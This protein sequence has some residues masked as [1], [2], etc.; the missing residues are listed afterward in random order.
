MLLAGV[1][2][3]MG[4]TQQTQ[5]TAGGIQFDWTISL[6]TILT[7]VSGM[8]MTFFFI[9][10][11]IVFFVR[12]QWQVQEIDREL[13]GFRDGLMQFQTD[14]KLLGGQVV[15]ALVA[16][17]RLEGREERNEDKQSSFFSDMPPWRRP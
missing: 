15:S 12:L 3:A 10:G 2:T 4:A 13:K 16:I 7:I 5:L 17:G 9:V 6:G 11:L 14:F 1:Q 8:A